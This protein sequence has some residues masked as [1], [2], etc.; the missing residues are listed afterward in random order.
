ME[1]LETSRSKIVRRSASAS[2]TVVKPSRP[3][4]KRAMAAVTSA[5]TG[6]PPVKPGFVAKVKPEDSTFK[7]TA[8]SAV[9]KK[10][11]AAWDTKGRLQDMEDLAGQLKDKVHSSEQHVSQIQTQLQSSEVRGLPIFNRSD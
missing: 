10:K 3:P 6:K 8:D 1:E 2:T 7:S 9:V 4:A 11:R 5:Q